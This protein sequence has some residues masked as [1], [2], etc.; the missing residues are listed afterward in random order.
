[1]TKNDKSL[2]LDRDSFRN[3]VFERDKYMCVICGAIDVNGPRLDAHHVVERR[4]FDDGGYYLDNGATLCDDMEGRTGCHM[5]AEQTVISC[6]EVRRAAGIQRVVLPDHL[7]H[8]LVYDKWGNI[9]N[10]D[11]TRTKG[12]LFGDESVRKVLAAGGVMPLF[13]DRVKYPRTYHLPWSPGLIDDDRQLEST[14]LFEGKDVVVTEKMDGENTTMY[15]DYIHARSIDSGSHPSRGWVKNLHST[16]RSSIPNGWRLCGENL[17]A[18]HSVRYDKLPSYFMLFSIWDENNTC[19]SW[20]ETCDYAA[21]LD[22]QTV[23]VL[24][25]GTWNEAKIREIERGL[26]FKKTE[27][28]VVRVADSFSYGAFR[29]SVAKYVR[30]DHV[31]TTHNWMM[32]DV[33]KNG[34][35][36]KGLK[37]RQ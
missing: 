27:G 21:I 16:I 30:K 17:F 11:G 4:L 36:V 1:M 13:R 31:L 3:A 20:D 6:E 22:L 18:E 24:Y 34:L 5:K 29:R 9:I 25:R 15:H 8:D 23:P 32:K 7:Y 28:Y 37:E 14:S 26:D 33:V 2:L 12:E 19:L 10:Q 35:S